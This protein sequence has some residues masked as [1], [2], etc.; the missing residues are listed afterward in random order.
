MLLDL[1]C[2]TEVHERQLS[3]STVDHDVFRLEVSKDHRF[4]ME[5]VEHLQG[6]SAEILDNVDRNA[7]LFSLVVVD[8]YAFNRGHHEASVLLVSDEC[9]LERRE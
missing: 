4:G 1:L 8:A 6:H 7:Y 9:R 2:E 5:L 3:R